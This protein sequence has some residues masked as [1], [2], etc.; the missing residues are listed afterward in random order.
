[1]N[2]DS[3]NEGEGEGAPQ[4]PLAQ[5][6]AGDPAFQPGHPSRAR[7]KLCMFALVIAG[8]SAGLTLAQ[9]RDRGRPRFWDQDSGPFVRTEGGI[10]VNEDTVRTAR[11]TAPHSVDWPAWTNAPGFE[12]DVFTFTR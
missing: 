7:R 6:S 2:L 1:M 9:F 4:F 8:V 3:I 10:L 11:E 5:P 12:Q